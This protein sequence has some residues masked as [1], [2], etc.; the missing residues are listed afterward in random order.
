[1]SWIK[2][3]GKRR[4]SRMEMSR[5]LLLTSTSDPGNEMEANS[6]KIADAPLANSGPPVKT[7]LRVLKLPLRPIFIDCLEDVS[8]P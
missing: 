8:R 2:L 5:V 7:Y 4:V 3:L 6:A 1:M